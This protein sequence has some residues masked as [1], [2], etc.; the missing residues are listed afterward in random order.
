[1]LPKLQPG[2]IFTTSSKGLMDDA[3]DFVQ[4]F[5][6]PD[7][8]STQTHCGVILNS[9][10]ET[11]ESKFTIRRGN[12]SKYQNRTIRVYRHPD[13][14]PERFQAGW[15]LV[16]SHEGQIYPI[17]RWPLFILGLAEEVVILPKP[18]CSE[19]TTKF[20]HGADLWE[21]SYWGV[22]VNELDKYLQ[23]AWNRI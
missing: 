22:D 17:H 10:G 5:W 14:T 1:M 23:K 19:L 2:D 21:G 9:S 20:M 6:S 3:I 11:F 12:I 13:M 4:A 18:V 7:K 16:K 15:E 8:K